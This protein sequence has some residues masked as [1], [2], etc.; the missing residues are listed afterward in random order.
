MSWYN[1]GLREDLGAVFPAAF[2]CGL[3]TSGTDLDAVSSRA[4]E[5]NFLPNL[6]SAG[7]VVSRR[8]RGRCRREAASGMIRT[9]PQATGVL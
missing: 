4:V 2:N 3:P 5:G 7:H 6:R 9:T 8:Q 1:P